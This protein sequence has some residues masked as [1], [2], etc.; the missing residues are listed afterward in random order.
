MPDFHNLISLKYQQL[1][2][3]TLKKDK[4]YYF[5]FYNKRRNFHSIF[6]AKNSDVELSVLEYS[7][8]LYQ[9]FM[10]VLKNEDNYLQ[11]FVF[12]KG[13]VPRKKMSQVELNKFSHYVIRMKALND[14]A[15]V[16]FLLYDPARPIKVS[17]KSNFYFTLDANDE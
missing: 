5:D 7:K 4:V 15:K 1:T 2:E 3:K 14:D 8:L 12:K 6:Y 17:H 10:T 13:D 11:K 16:F 9:D